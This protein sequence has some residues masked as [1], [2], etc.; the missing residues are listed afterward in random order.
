MSENVCFYFMIGSNLY[1]HTIF[2]WYYNTK[3]LESIKKK[4]KIQKIICHLNVL[5]ILTN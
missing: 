1:S 4:S 2:L 3:Y 5:N